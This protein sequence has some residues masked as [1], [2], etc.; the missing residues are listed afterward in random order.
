MAILKPWNHFTSTYSINDFPTTASS[1]QDPSLHPGGPFPTWL[2]PLRLPGHHELNYITVLIWTHPSP[3]NK[4]ELVH[5]TILQS[6]HGI[7]FPNAPLSAF[8]AS[9]PSTT[10]LALLHGL[11]E[12]RAMRQINTFGATAGLRLW[13]EMGGAKYWVLSHTS[14]LGYAGILMRLMG[15]YDTPRTVE[16]A[17]E[18]EKTENE[19][20][21]KEEVQ[22]AEG[23]IG[24]GE[25]PEVVEVDNGACFVLA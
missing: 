9:S 15:V 25:V 17:V 20:T 3:S 7:M 2:T 16:W 8:L 13:R 5:E 11:K 19:K 18:Q 24:K 4:D 6:P 1:W 22:G 23:N 14:V 21:E 12:S 10:K